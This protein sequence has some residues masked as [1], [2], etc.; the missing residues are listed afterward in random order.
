MTGSEGLDKIAD[1]ETITM[2]KGQLKELVKEAVKD[3]VEAIANKKPE[4]TKAEI[5]QEPN[6][7]KRLKLIEEN[8]HLFK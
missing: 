8:M 7:A 1:Q 4:L 2:T 3:A 5:M 6:R